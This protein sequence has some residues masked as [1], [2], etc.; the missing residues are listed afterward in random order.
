MALKVWRN[1]GWYFKYKDHNIFY[2]DEGKGEVLVLIH[3]FPT[4][5]WDWHKL[6]PVLK[7]KFHLITLDMLGFGFSDKPLKHHYSIHGQADLFEAILSDL[8]VT[9]IH[10]LA[11]DYGDTVTQE[12]LA[13]YLE[14]RDN[15][16]KGL[17]IH[18]VCMLNG[19]LFPEM[20]R[21]LRIQKLL[22]GPLGRFLLP[23]M[24]RDRL[25]KNLN[26][27]FGKNTQPSENEVDEFWE[28][29]THKSGKNVVRRLIRYMN[30]R[31]QYRERWLQALQKADIPLRLLIGDADP[32]SGKQIACRF[33][34]LIPAPDVV[35][36]D[37][38]GHYP[39]VEAPELVL[40]HYFQFVGA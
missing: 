15:G 24:G 26:A 4:A 11:H 25:H 13:R 6:W 27:I 38:I 32:V 9:D 10:I 17:N 36:L 29:L 3:G 2:I 35:L 14:R 21:P 19:G 28:L 33:K 22:L 31:V 40:K 23:F 16:Q 18:S 1:K 5:S 8:G 37:D 34:E 30:E 39:Q 20:H 7:S 12:L